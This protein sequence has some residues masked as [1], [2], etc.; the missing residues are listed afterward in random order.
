MIRSHPTKVPKGDFGTTY[1]Q[2]DP[3]A[4]G[5]CREKRWET[6]GV[7][8]M[9]LNIP[10]VGYSMY[11]GYVQVYNPSYGTYNPLIEVTTLVT[12]HVS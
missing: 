10:H 4:F 8:I 9:A 7:N 12:I 11:T 2:L 6:F 1:P 5:V 3:S